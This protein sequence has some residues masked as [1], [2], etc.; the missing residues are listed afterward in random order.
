MPYRPSITRNRT[1]VI[2]VV[3]A[4]HRIWTAMAD[5]P[6]EGILKELKSAP[7]AAAITIYEWELAKAL[8][9]QE[10]MV[11]KYPVWRRLRTYPWRLRGD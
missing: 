1:Y 4:D 11:G 3:D 7:P 8:N 9:P 2:E 6:D 10:F 5:N